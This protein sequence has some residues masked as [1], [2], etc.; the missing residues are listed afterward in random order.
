MGRRKIE[1]KMV[2]DSG[3]RQVTFSKRR[4]GLFKKANEL[5]TLCAAQVAIVVFSPGGKPY[6]FGHP[7][8]EAVA[9]RFLTLNLRSRVSIPRQLVAQLQREAKVERLSR[10]LNAI[11]KKLQAEMKRGE[12]LDEAVKAA[13]KRSK[14]RKPIN[15]L[16]LHELIEIRKAMGQL[17]ERVKQRI[18]EIEASSS[19]LLLSKMATKQAESK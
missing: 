7:S 12:I 14:F 18:S 10:R 16:N 2:K 9:E 5:A 8:V 19:L 4:S 13:R 11:L 6:S 15:E 3:S 1:M 17:R